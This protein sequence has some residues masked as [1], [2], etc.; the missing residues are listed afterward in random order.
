MRTRLL[1]TFLF[2]F[3][4]LISLTG[5]PNFLPGQS[6]N[7][8]GS[9]AAVS[10]QLSEGAESV[11]VTVAGKIL[12]T[13]SQ[14]ETS[15][16]LVDFYDINSKS[17]TSSRLSLARSSMAAVAIGSTAYFL[18]GNAPGV[19]QSDRIDIYDSTN[20]SWTI[21]SLT[22]ARSAPA[23]VGIGNQLLVGGG[24]SQNP[25]PGAISTI[26]VIDTDSDARQSFSLSTPRAQLAAV[27]MGTKAYFI[28]GF[29]CFTSNTPSCD[30]LNT[31]DVFDTNTNSLTTISMPHGRGQ[32]SAAVI[33]NKI[34][35]AAGYFHEAFVN[36]MDIYDTDSLQWSSTPLSVVGEGFGGVAVGQYFVI[37]GGGGTGYSE[38]PQNLFIYDSVSGQ[39]LGTALHTNRYGMAVA[40]D[41]TYA[42]FAGGK[43]SASE[44]DLTDIEWINPQ[45]GV[46]SVA[47][48]Q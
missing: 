27:A 39:T 12:F 31:I 48:A 3:I 38:D 23:A 14:A 8:P 16:G 42:I 44:A 32:P 11:A 37:G 43:R 20:D 47:P 5:C 13:G 1:P 35:I 30:G 10:H 7:A 9:S 21:D 24:Y 46:I 45:T 34:Y 26:E 2:Y 15:N 4:L 19:S 6:A 22:T 25:S 18:G 36:T 29:A 33:G 41:G 28:G 17:W 40:T